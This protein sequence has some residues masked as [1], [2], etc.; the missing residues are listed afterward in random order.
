MPQTFG[1]PAV[2]QYKP[3]FL[4]TAHVVRQEIRVYDSVT[5]QYI[6]LTT[7]SPAPTV[8]FSTQAT[9]YTTLGLPSTIFG[10]YALTHRG[11]GTWYALVTAD[12]VMQYLGALVG[13]L[14]YQIVEGNYGTTYHDLSNVQPLMVTDPYAPVVL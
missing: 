5:D 4:H 2:Q 14:I 3:I 7:L 13:T 6:A 9:G 11:S 8:R 12:L 10:P 1:A